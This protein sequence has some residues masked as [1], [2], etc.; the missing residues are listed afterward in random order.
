MVT[1]EEKTKMRRRV[2]SLNLGFM[3]ENKDVFKSIH[4]QIANKCSVLQG[5]KKKKG[6]NVGVHVGKIP[7]YGREQT[8]LVFSCI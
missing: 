1:C 5:S 4:Q 3:G 2:T 7:V 6:L 8:I